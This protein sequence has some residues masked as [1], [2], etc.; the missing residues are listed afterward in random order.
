MA[1]LLPGQQ[2]LPVAEHHPVL[3]KGKW[4]TL[5]NAGEDLLTLHRQL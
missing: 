3:L 5:L 2:P 4:P 1:S